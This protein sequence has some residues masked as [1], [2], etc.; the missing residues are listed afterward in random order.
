MDGRVVESNP[1]MQRMLGYSAEELQGL[2]FRTFT[3]P[4]DVDLDLELFQE[5][6]EGKRDHYQIELRYLRK[7]G[8]WGWVRLTVS[9]VRAVGGKPE[10]A[11]GITE[12][13]TER[14]RAEEQLR[15]AHKMEAIGRLAGGVAHDFNNLLTGIGLYCDL[16]ISSLGKDS[17]QRH[18]VEEI[19]LA[20]EHGAGLIQQLMAVARP[21]AVEPQ[22]LSLNDVVTEM[23]GLLSHLIGENIHLSKRLAPDLRGVKMDPTQAQQIVLNLVL[24]ARDAMPQGGHIEVETGNVDRRFPSG[25][26]VQRGPWV[27]LMVADDGCGMDTGTRARL[28]EPFFTTKQPGKGNGL[29][30]STVYNAVKQSGGNIGVETEPGRGT[31]IRILLPATEESCRAESGSPD[32]NSAVNAKEAR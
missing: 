29:G 27:Q 3:H 18:Y 6:V 13:I 22:I 25:K 4:E 20:G 30:L 32:R 31:C 17:R 14:K 11:I 15:E 1:A 26:G 23:T 16:L 8:G 19:R 7:D 10:F 2:H 28:F 5:M 9:A 12:E 21:H 24:N